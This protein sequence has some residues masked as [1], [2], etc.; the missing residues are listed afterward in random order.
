MPY[1]E[2][3]VPLSISSSEPLLAVRALPAQEGPVSYTLHTSSGE[4]RFSLNRSTGE[5]TVHSKAQQR[6]A[7]HTGRSIIKIYCTMPLRS[8][9][10]CRICKYFNFLSD[11]LPEFCIFIRL[12]A[13]F[14][15]STTS[16]LSTISHS[17]LCNACAN[18]FFCPSPSHSLFNRSDGQFVSRLYIVKRS[19][20]SSGLQ[21]PSIN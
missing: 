18:R 3:A 17:L 4:H 13:C 16:I 8:Q 5:L 7:E 11:M 21:S 12:M 14:F 9:V 19:A 15:L 20:Y 2:M 1:I 10:K 6:F